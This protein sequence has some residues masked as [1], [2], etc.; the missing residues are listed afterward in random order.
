MKIII[1]IPDEKKAKYLI[2][3]LKDIPYIKN[4]EIEPKKRKV[5]PD[6]ES[7]YG[8]WKD[9]DISLKEIRKKA[10]RKC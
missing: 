2:N 3:L 8:I 6:F 5:R 10:W 7:V 4:I 1:D 9:R